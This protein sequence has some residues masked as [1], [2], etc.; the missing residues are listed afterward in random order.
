MSGWPEDELTAAVEAYR[1]IEARLASG[2]AELEKAK[3]YR[4]LAARYG[5]SA[6]AWEYR[7]QNISHVLSQAGE[8]W[9]PGL[10]P[11]ANVGAKIEQQ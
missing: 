1:Q 7:M 9:L 5:R 2:S 11:A 3:V 6:K 8:P 10:R 4:K